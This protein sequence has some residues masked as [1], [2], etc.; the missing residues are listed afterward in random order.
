MSLPMLYRVL[1]FRGGNVNLDGQS[2]IY[3]E[4]TVGPP[5]YSASGIR[6][7]T[8]GTIDRGQTTN[9]TSVSSIVWTQIDASTDWIIP[10]GDANG[11]YE[12]KLDVTS[13][14]PNVNSDSTATWIAVDSGSQSSSYL[15]WIRE[16]STSGIENWSWTLRIRYN[17]GAELDDGAYAGTNSNDLF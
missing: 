5:W 10:N 6:V 12:F 1:A 2:G 15:Q 13:N 8:D 17:G 4:D 9:G 11:N 14:A 3:S 16:K 7:N